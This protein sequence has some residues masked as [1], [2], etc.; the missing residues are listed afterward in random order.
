MFSKQVASFTWKH[1][2][3]LVR[4]FDPE[5]MEPQPGQESPSDD[6]RRVLVV[7]PALVKRGRAS[8]DDFQV[9]AGRLKMEAFCRL[10]SRAG[11]EQVARSPA[12]ASDKETAQGYFRS[13]FGLRKAADRQG[14]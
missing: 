13:R 9:E 3:N 2:D 4:T 12:R 14:Q 6:R 5:A 1:P 10:R 7:A 11:A 8:G